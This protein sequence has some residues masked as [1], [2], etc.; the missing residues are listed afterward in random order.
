MDGTHACHSSAVYAVLREMVT[1]VWLSISL[2]NC[3]ELAFYFFR[4]CS[5]P[6]RA[7]GS[8][9]YRIQ[10]RVNPCGARGG[11]GRSHTAVW[12]GRKR[13]S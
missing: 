11:A 2:D 6:V 4:N 13:E 5:E 10:V 9:R 1:P 8:V 12:N 7:C 3:S